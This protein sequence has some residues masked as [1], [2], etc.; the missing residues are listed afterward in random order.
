[1]NAVI[2]GAGAIGGCLGGW[3][4]EAYDTVW[5]YDQ[6]QVTARLREQGLWLYPEH[7]EAEKKRVDVRVIDALSDAPKPDVVFIAVKNYSL[8]AVAQMVKEQIGDDLLVVGLQNGVFNQSVLPRLFKRVLYAVI[9]FNAWVDE[10]GVIGYQNKGPFV[11][12]TLATA[13]EQGGAE[14]GGGQGGA[15]GDTEQG[16][17]ARGDTQGEDARL[18][19]NT[20]AAWMSKAVETI[21]TD[22]IRDAALCKM[23]INLT[24]SF[25]TLVGFK[26]REIESMPLFKRILSNSM[27]EGVSILKAAGVREFKVDTMP[28]WTKIWASATLPDFLT[29][30]IFKKNL[31]K[32]VLSSMAQDILQR[33]SGVSE[34][35]TLLGYFVQLA[36]QYQVAAPYNRTVYQLCQREFAKDP[37]VPLTETEVF[38]EIEAAL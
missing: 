29:N 20:V 8:E 11:L 13:G 27:N 9:E 2:I 15:Q 33:K 34:L 26:Y 36:D 23:V 1:M 25:T 19:A 18:D 16:E 28:S 7:G 12:G 4:S 21:A 14:Q 10:P 3:L 5:L 30:G 31:D 22:R 17:A 24:N 38:S 6:P 35:D 32:M 37:F